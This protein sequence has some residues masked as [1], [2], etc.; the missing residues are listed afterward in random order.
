LTPSLEDIV[1]VAAAH[2]CR[3]KRP[4]IS[5][6]QG[7]EGEPTLQADLIEE[8]I[9]RVRK[10]TRRGLIHLNTN[11]SRPDA[12]ARL[13][14]AGLQS[15]RIA[16]NSARAEVYC[17]YF[18]PRGYDLGTVRESIRLSVRLGLRTALN[19]L[20]FPGVN[21]QA[22]EAEALLDLLA[23]T[24]PHAVQW[25]SLCLDPDRY[26]ACLP[27]SAR[28]GPCLG[29]RKFMRLI[30]DRCPWLHTGNFNPLPP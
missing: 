2:L 27:R 3:A 23:E 12:I 1:T 30:K 24:K 6:G 9:H 15:V 13:A 18:R 25:R 20:V 5:F 22:D 29:M 28:T 26:L 8:A 14:G 4:V 19:L 11:G 17:A 10:L 21:D 16:L 7:C